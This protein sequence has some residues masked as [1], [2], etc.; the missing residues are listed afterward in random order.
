MV[1]FGVSWTK[2]CLTLFVPLCSAQL[3]F[4]STRTVPFQITLQH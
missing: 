4:T 1:M 2:F 3:M